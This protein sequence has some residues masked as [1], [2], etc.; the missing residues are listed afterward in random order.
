MGTEET[1]GSR[2]LPPATDERRHTVKPPATGRLAPSTGVGEQSQA[3]APAVR[4]RAEV[5]R[6]YQR[7]A[8]SKPQAQQYDLRRFVHGDGMGWFHLFAHKVDL[9][10]R[11]SFL[12]ITQFVNLLLRW[13]WYLVQRAGAGANGRM[14]LQPAPE[15]RPGSASATLVCVM[16]L[17]FFMGVLVGPIALP[18]RADPRGFTLGAQGSSNWLKAINPWQQAADVVADM[19]AEAQQQASAAPAPALAVREPGDHDVRG[20]PTVSAEQID[21]I[22]ASYSSPATGSGAAWVAMGQQY[23][24][25]P[26]YAVA[27]FIQESTAGT[28]SGWAGWK[29]DG[30]TTHNIGNIICAGYPTCYGRFRDYPSW[31]AGIG[32]WYKLIAVEYIEGRGTTTVAEILPIYAPS[33]ENDTQAYIRTVEQM[34]DKWRGGGV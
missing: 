11:P 24:I 27:F 18:A 25:D 28:A 16:L 8:P 6:P 4:P 30:S 22:L 26:A 7:A 12:L 19:L 14:A 31:E 5:Y 1:T 32:D 13:S 17:L 10:I 20:A 33:F 15:L 2:A 29:S 21:T 3:T 23:G 9:I 34:V